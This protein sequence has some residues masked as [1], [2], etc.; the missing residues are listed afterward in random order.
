[1]SNEMRVLSLLQPWA[2]LWA[3]GAKQNETRS[4]GTSYRGEVAVHASRGF[5]RDVRNICT[6][7]PFR[8]ALRDLGFASAEELPRGAIIGSVMVTGCLRMVGGRSPGSATHVEYVLD[9]VPPAICLCGLGK[10]AERLSGKERD[11][12]EWRAGRVAW[13]T[14]PLTRR[15]PATPIPFKG[16][17]GLRKLPDEIAAM[18]V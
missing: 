14:D 6:I 10:C 3:S 12:G 9:Y 11:F 15:R 5:D 7:E 1:M 8:S 18:L 13:T 16:G 17:L 2:T 4:W